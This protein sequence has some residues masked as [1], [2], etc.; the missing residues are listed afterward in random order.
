MRS[1]ILGAIV[2]FVAACSGN[3]PAT[4]VGAGPN[5][6]PGASDDPSNGGD[7]GP[8]DGGPT[9]PPFVPGTKFAETALSWTVGDVGESSA[10]FP[11]TIGNLQ[12]TVIDI[13][14]DDK[15]DLVSSGRYVSNGSGASPRVWGDGTASP[16]WK[17]F[18]N[19]GSG[20]STTPKVWPV[21]NVGDETGARFPYSVG[22]SQWAL[23]DIDGDGKPDLV[24]SGRYVSNG[25]GASPRVW[26]DGTASPH[27]KV[28]TNTGSGF[29]P[30][31]K[32][33]PVS[34]LGDETAR[35]PH[36]IADSQWAVVD[37]N[38]D[39][40]P[41]LVSSGRYVS[42]GSGASPRV[43]GDATASPH[44]KVF[45]N[46]GSGFASSATLW[47]VRNIGE[48]AD[49]FPSLI[50]D[51]QWALIDVDGDRKPDFV[52]SGRYVS[53]GSGASPR[54]WGDGT[55]SP[56]WKV[57]LNTG[58]GFASNVTTWSVGDL[59]ETAPRFPETIGGSQWSVVDI[60]GDKKPDLVS[61]GRYVSNGSGASPR[62]WGDGSASPHWKVFLNTG[63]GF[64]TSPKSWPVRDVGAENGARYPETIAST[65]FALLDIDGD[66]KPDLVS[67][68][69]YVSNGSG[70]SPR[71]WGDGTAS[72]FWKVYLNQ[73]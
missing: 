59:G 6:G 10:R 48:G 56:H 52:S 4:D 20:F 69:R 31:A 57:F 71:V 24:S 16:H 26:G 68:G 35:H 39:G 29:S 61:S 2:T 5:G 30:T 38:G 37:M 66:R 67:S 27:W 73:P 36:F 8:S 60:D 1:V 23:I 62:V 49:R 47:P 32:L 21:S 3:S 22:D 18:T 54:V 15:P 41:D 58:S 11:E 53:N 55:A 63:S 14:G 9:E 50:A 7:G 46:T 17:V 64:A 44:W 25:S 72:P 33:W 34:N 65:Q 42:N 19:T 28:F 40:K 12:W 70:A 43:W 45:L 13:D 51:S